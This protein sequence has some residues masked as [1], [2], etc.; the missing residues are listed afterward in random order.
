MRRDLGSAVRSRG[1]MREPMAADETERAQPDIHDEIPVR[2]QILNDLDAIDKQVFDRVSHWSTPL[3]DATVI[4]VAEATT[5]S[6]VSIGIAAVLSLAG[7]ARGRRAAGEGLVAV[8]LTGAGANA[9]IGQATKRR[10]RRIADTEHRGTGAPPSFPSAQT[11]SA[12]A[13]AG[14]VG[15]HIPALRLPLNALAASVGFSRVYAGLHY[16]RDVLAGWIVGKAIAAAVLR[17][18]AALRQRRP[19]A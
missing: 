13:F 1:T 19:S 17:V 5:Y 10:Q 2:T 3:L 15:R 16:P 4:P 9:A 12:A 7:G 8:G 11:A 6:R 18:G 14:V